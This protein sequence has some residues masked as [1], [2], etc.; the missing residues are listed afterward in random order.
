MEP[1][2]KNLFAG[3]LKVKAGE[4]GGLDSVRL[5]PFSSE[6]YLCRYNLSK[7][8][9]LSE[10][11]GTLP[12][13]SYVVPQILFGAT[14]EHSKSASEPLVPP[15]TVHGDLTPALRLMVSGPVD[16]GS[17]G[18]QGN[19][20]LKF[21][22]GLL[23]YPSTNEWLTRRDLNELW[24]ADLWEKVGFD[25]RIFIRNGSILKLPMETFKIESPIDFE[26]IPDRQVQRLCDVIRIDRKG[27]QSLSRGLRTRVQSASGE[28]IRETY[29]F[30]NT[31]QFFEIKN[32][33]SAIPDR[34]KRFLA[35]NMLFTYWE[36]SKIPYKKR[37]QYF[38]DLRLLVSSVSQALSNDSV[39]AGC[40]PERRSINLKNLKQVRI[41]A[42]R[43]Y[44][45]HS[46]DFDKL[47]E[48]LENERAHNEQSGFNEVGLM[49][50]TLPPKS[51]Q[52]RL[53]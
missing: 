31:K 24:V 50:F 23:K 49:L 33:T 46:A 11:G 8:T 48:K 5:D 21:S 26:N 9:F 47:D 35:I 7:S 32:V 19:A 16:P 1:E 30:A 6:Y 53:V 39:E 51:R 44:K 3:E 37:V 52:K 29:A 14:K 45:S 2:F 10:S 22:A 15:R 12:F 43:H 18:Y 41:R 40:L 36:R 38:K 34:I 25:Y 20:T 27:A 4:G 13:V 42:A 28:E 17:N